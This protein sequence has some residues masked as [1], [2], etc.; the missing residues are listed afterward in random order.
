[1]M[2][3][4]YFHFFILSNKTDRYGSDAIKIGLTE[5]VKTNSIEELVNFS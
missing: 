5:K 2:K 4:M 1:M 3:F